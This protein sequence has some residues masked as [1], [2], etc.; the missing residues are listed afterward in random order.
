MGRGLLLCNGSLR[1]RRVA[2]ALLAGRDGMVL[3]LLGWLLALLLRRRL[4]RLGT[5]A[6]VLELR[7]TPSHVR[8]RLRVMGGGTVPGMRVVS[9][10][11][12]R[13]RRLLQRRHRRCLRRTP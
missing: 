9:E 11:V 7:V 6:I 13:L 8:G 12:L 4:L 10:R 1:R 5:V 3:A 2:H